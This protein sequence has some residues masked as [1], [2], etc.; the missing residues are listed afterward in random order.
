MPNV[1]ANNLTIGL[2]AAQT[3]RIDAGYER[4]RSSELERKL[5]AAKR[6]ASI[7]SMDDASKLRL[8]EAGHKIIV[9]ES[10][11]EVL[12]AEL[13][14]RD[15]LIAAWMLTNESFK[16]LARSY[17]KKLGVSDQDR[18]ADFYKMILDVAEEDPSL[19]SPKILGEVKARSIN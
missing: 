12:E 13:K 3:A 9:A 19:A 5:A 18:Q 17:G 1:A 4:D 16:R 2:G 7:G 14:E 15:E 11:V 10:R 6:N 8:R